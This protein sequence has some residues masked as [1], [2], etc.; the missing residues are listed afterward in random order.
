[1]LKGINVNERIEFISKDDNSE[2]K[3]IFVF[4]PITGADMIKISEGAN[5]SELKLTSEKIFA[6]L[7]LTICEIKNFEPQG[8]IS[9]ML[10]SLQPLVLTEL[11]NEAMSLNR[12]TGQ[13]RK[14]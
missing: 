9:D 3:T 1:M 13:D 10:K 8:S 6:L 12:M 7:E 4:K 2:P 14:N 5:G 11:V